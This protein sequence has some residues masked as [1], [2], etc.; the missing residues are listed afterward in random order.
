MPEIYPAI[1]VLAITSL[2][3]GLPN[4]L[5]E[6]M[7]YGIPA[8]AT[9]VG[10]IP[11]VL[12]HGDDGLLVPPLDIERY[13]KELARIVG[14]PALRRAMGGRARQKIVQNY[15]FEQRVKNVERLYIDALHTAGAKRR[16]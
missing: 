16:S 12:R 3:E 9:A 6:A 4:V 1:D 5:L 14:D 7:L 15:L 8:V 13:S 2:R 11:D 10:G